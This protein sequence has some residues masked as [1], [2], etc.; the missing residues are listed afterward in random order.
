MLKARIRVARPV[1]EGVDLKLVV[2]IRF[3]MV[4]EV[5]ADHVVGKL[6]R[7]GAIK[8]ESKLCA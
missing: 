7:R 2:G 1:L 6:S 3:K 5:M 8:S 4:F